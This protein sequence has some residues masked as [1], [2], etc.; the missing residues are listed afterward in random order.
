MKKLDTGNKTGAPKI[1]VVVGPTATGKSHLAVRL[2]KKFNG[3]IISAD[4]RQV[5]RGMN[6]GTGKISAR[7]MRG[8]KHHLLD[9]ASPN[10]AGFSGGGFNAARFKSRAEKIIA[11]ILR[12][13]KTPII[14]GGTGFWVDAVAFNREFPDVKPNRGLRKKLEG[15]SEAKL[16]AQLKRLDP[17]RAKAIDPKNK[18]RLVRAIEIAKTGL[19]FKD[20]RHAG[21]PKFQTL[22]I[23]L[24]MPK[25]ILEKQI[26]ARMEKRFK[27]GMVREVA[28]LHARGASWKILEN[29]GLE[30]K[31]ISLYLRKKISG[32]QT[33][34]LLFTAIKN[35]A[36]RQRTWLKR[37][38]SV[39]WL[40][41]DNK[42]DAF[43]RAVKLAKDFLL[44]EGMKR[45][46]R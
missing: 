46:G 7:E 34:D 4:S 16:F 6:I 3:E 17:L 9:V 31:F 29:F 30:Y 13:G 21:A 1:I 2:A 12:R 40:D 39:H 32:P 10:A 14:A 26:L 27:Q 8:I 20:F 19:K 38:K 45:R 36:K 42:P 25:E 33:R 11:D 18:R 28:R 22:F 43:A 35:Y 41:A 23:G 5:Y 37:N 15:M 44:W 24:D